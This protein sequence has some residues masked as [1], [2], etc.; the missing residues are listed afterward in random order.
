MT[1]PDSSTTP[2]PAPFHIHGWHGWVHADWQDL[3][4]FQDI[5]AW[6]QEHS[7]KIILDLPCRTITR[8]QTDRG[9]LYAKYMRAKNDGVIKNR[10]MLSYLRWTVLPSRGQR[11]FLT[12]SAMLRKGHFCPLPVLGGRCRRGPWGYPHELFVSAELV[13]PTVEELLQTQDASARENILTRCG[14][15]LQRFHADHFVHGDFLPRNACLNTATKQLF[16]LDND[17]T[18]L[19]PCPPPFFCQRRNLAQFCYNLLLQAGCYDLAMPNAF[20]NAYLQATS[21]TEKRRQAEYQR[22]V[23]HITARWQRFGE[24][25][26][27]RLK[28]LA[29]Q[30]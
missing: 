9:A 25:E 22:V 13:Q 3:P 15:E 14:S 4:A 24:K 1:S 8:H 12:C 21:W 27:A 16:Y 10:E 20:L 6:L 19:W 7:A 28:R 11:I 5:D 18:R 26:A 23:A 2:K 17:R 29:K 30:A